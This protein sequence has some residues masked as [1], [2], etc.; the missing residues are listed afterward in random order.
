MV[1]QTKRKRTKLKNH[2]PSKHFAN[3]PVGSGEV[4]LLF[5]EAAA[6]QR[7]GNLVA[8]EQ[9]CRRILEL[10]PHHDESRCLLGVVLH[11]CGRNDEAVEMLAAAI[12]STPTN[13]NYYKNLILVL[14]MIGQLDRAEAFMTSALNINTRDW[15][16]YQAL[17]NLFFKEKRLKTAAACYRKVLAINPQ[18][19]EAH[20]N[21]GGALLALDHIDEAIHSYLNV[22]RLDP[23]IADAYYNI[24]NAY[25]EKGDLEKSIQAYEKTLIL[26][27]DHAQACFNLANCLKSTGQ[28]DSAIQYYRTCIR[29]TP[30][31]FGVIYNLGN[32]L[33]AAGRWNEAIRAFQEALSIDPQHVGALHNLGRAAMEAGAWDEA[34]RMFS[35]VIDRD[36]SYV[37]AYVNRGN[38]YKQ[39]NQ[40]DHAIADYRKVLELAPDH[41]D[42][43]LNL[44]SELIKRADFE[45][46]LALFK[47]AVDL[48]SKPSIAWWYYYLGLPIAYRSEEE[49][50]NHRNRFASG[51]A[52]LVKDVALDAPEDRQRALRGIGS[53]TTFYLQYQGRNDLQ[54]QKQYGEFIHRV[55]AAN[56]PEWN[57]DIRM[58][59][60][61]QGR[62]IR[63]GYVS[64]YMQAHT[65]GRFLLGWIEN[66]DRS[67]FEI[68]C[69]YI[70]R[71]KDPVTE[72]FVQKSDHFYQ[73]YGDL[74]KVARQIRADDLHILVFTD[75][76]MFAPASQLAG[77]RLA[78]VQ[79][80][81]WGHPV[82]TGL[83]T[84]DYYLSSDLMEPEN[85]ET[86]Y[87][88][89]LVRLPNLALAYRP[90]VMPDNPLLRDSFGLNDDDFVYLSS[91]S[92]FKYLP[93]H[94]AIYARI[95]ES[96]PRAKFVFIANASKHITDQ[97]KER[98]SIHF[99]ARDLNMDDYCR[100][101]QRLGF[102]DFLC[103]NL[104]SDVLL[105][106]LTWSGGKTTLE[107]ISC[108][109]PVVTLPGQFMRGRHAFAMLKMMGVTETIA[110]DVDEY[111]SIACRLGRDP[112]FYRRIQK[113]VVDNCSR[114][115][116]DVSCVRGLE[117]FYLK[118]IKESISQ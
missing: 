118:V 114:L 112:A 43:L 39:Q 45:E 87:S 29:L 104:A 116:N 31:D 70:N 68:H 60:V 115:Y 19:K 27:P 21:L 32:A 49:I 103:L 48:E 57:K 41:F 26:F 78:A 35:Q 18:S 66:H 6:A 65:V 38:A 98:L 82:T 55:M 34:E 74:E 83:P 13:L 64:S 69:Y 2:R 81:G 51:L 63:I 36:S 50:E 110:L 61:K 56:F 117:S 52:K 33:Y 9:L 47:Q 12:E 62:R 28:I 40:I 42:T 46:G 106:T 24:G 100:F 16:T 44:G 11:Q 91:Q 84:I 79:C 72:E 10:Q 80:K 88:E 37:N 1:K 25:K 99:A 86:H 95:A 111:I 109:L 96:V 15:Q 71:L 67:K 101:Q 53:I 8:A 97:F 22:I 89:K 59:P 4:Q 20:N 85:G 23:S 113:A 94:D 107:G 102:N 7:N 76:G 17:G 3:R 54:L 93:Q 75:I 92:L 77:L 73:I 58:P 108:G 90:P 14:K 5:A 30:N 105:D